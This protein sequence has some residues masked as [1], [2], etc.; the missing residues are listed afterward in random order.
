MN[1]FTNRDRDQL[2]DKLAG[3]KN[4]NASSGKKSDN[5]PRKQTAKFE[6]ELAGHSEQILG[7]IAGT[8]LAFGAGYEPYEA[9]ARKD[10][11]SGQRP[12]PYP[13]QSFV[14]L[15]DSF[16]VNAMGRS[17]AANQGNQMYGGSSFSNLPPG[18]DASGGPRGGPYQPLNQDMPDL[19]LLQNSK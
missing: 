13:D 4:L 10:Q 11:A 8:D 6:T 7:E 1:V 9:A 2:R 18:H 16:S 17:R 15:G 5:M 12:R 19:A 14:N 3:G